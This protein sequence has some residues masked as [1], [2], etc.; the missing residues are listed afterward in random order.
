VNG[1]TANREHLRAVVHNT[2]GIV[3]ALT[4]VIGYA[5]ASA[6][7]QEALDRSLPVADVVLA[8]DLLTADEL[9]RVLRPET[10]ARVNDRETHAH[11]TD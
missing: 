10:L 5:K 11:A 4:P 3:T 9:Q 8:Q 6:A 7:A 2:I 1:I